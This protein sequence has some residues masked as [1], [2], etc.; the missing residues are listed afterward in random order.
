MRYKFTDLLGEIE[1]E[2]DSI[3]SFGMVVSNVG[4]SSSQIA[5][6]G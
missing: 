5:L 2:M 6:A 3:G 1:G 4:S